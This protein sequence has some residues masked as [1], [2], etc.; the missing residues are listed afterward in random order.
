ML[1][2]EQKTLASIYVD[3]PWL[4]VQKLKLTTTKKDTLTIIENIYYEY[5]KAEILSE[6]RVT[7][8][9]VV[10]VMKGNPNIY[11]EIYAH[12]D[13]RST[14]DYNQKLS[15]KRAK[16]A[17][18]YILSKGIDKSRLAGKGLGESKILNKC[19]DGIECS[20]EEHSKNR[21]TEFKIH[22]KK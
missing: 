21:R 15:D 18:D 13:S 17:V 6:A 4:Q 1:P 7:L 22:T 10:Q 12:T 5:D 2:S 11:I 19:K 3:D 8:D 20:E 14:A 16:A 9:K